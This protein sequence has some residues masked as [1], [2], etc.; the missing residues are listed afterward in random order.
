MFAL[1]GEAKFPLIRQNP[2]FSRNLGDPYF[3]K[4][5]RLHKN[6]KRAKL[7]HIYC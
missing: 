7:F 3:L 6:F 4:D 1:G 5:I 2:S